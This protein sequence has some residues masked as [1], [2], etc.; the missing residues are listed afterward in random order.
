MYASN[1]ATWAANNMDAP[2]RSRALR[3]LPAQLSVSTKTVENHW[4]G[5]TAVKEQA[6]QGYLEYFQ[7]QGYQVTLNDLFTPKPIV[8]RETAS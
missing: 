4:Q 3:E 7:K 5:R 2:A 1:I 8:Q 6:A